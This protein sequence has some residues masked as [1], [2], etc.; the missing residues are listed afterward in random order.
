MARHEL[1]AIRTS[2]QQL[3]ITRPRSDSPATQR[4]HAFALQS[5][6][7]DGVPRS[8]SAGSTSHDGSAAPPGN[9]LCPIIAHRPRRHCAAG[10]AFDEHAHDTF[11]RAATC[12]GLGA[13]QRGAVRL[14]VERPGLCD[15]HAR[16]RRAVPTWN[17]GAERFKDTAPKRSSA[18]TSH[19]SIRR[20]LA[21]PA[22]TSLQSRRKSALSE[23]GDQEGRLIFWARRHH[24]GPERRRPVLR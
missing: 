8:Q 12:A 4:H 3:R 13:A 15:F 6:A 11:R 23:G 2:V 24:R 18:S 10:L 7:T 21:R 19:G 16:L 17:A 14:L 20:A 9:G 5:D 1:P 22:R